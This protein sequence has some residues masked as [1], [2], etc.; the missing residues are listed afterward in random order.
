MSHRVIS[1]ISPGP[2]FTSWTTAILASSCTLT[3][4]VALLFWADQRTLL[5][6]EDQI[7]SGI[8]TNSNYEISKSIDLFK[9]YSPSIVT[10]KLLEIAKVDIDRDLRQKRELV[11]TIQVIIDL[12]KEKQF[13][14]ARASWRRLQEDQRNILI[15]QQ[16]STLADARKLNSIDASLAKGENKVEMRRRVLAKLDKN[17]ES[18]HLAKQTFNLL[19]TDLTEAFQLPSNFSSDFD[20]DEKS[21]WYEEGVLKGLPRIIELPDDIPDLTSLRDLIQLKGG[22]VLQ[23]SS[24]P[25]QDFVMFMDQLKARS[26][27][28]RTEFTRLKTA[29][30]N[31]NLKLTDINNDLS[32][33]RSELIN[34][35]R[36]AIA[37]LVAPVR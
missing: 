12:I 3:L 35:M 18:T 28:L 23:T 32:Q 36:R 9:L 15:S 13:E 6:I 27:D 16:G 7:K 17:Q 1:H 10:S 14:K 29:H 11:S 26:S 4:S 20:N 30:A 19:Y 22:S 24:N 8:S 25:Q 2:G 21:L 34:W 31:L 37:S 5:A 33:L